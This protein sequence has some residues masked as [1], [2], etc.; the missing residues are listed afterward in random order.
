MFAFHKK[1]RKKGKNLIRIKSSG[2]LFDHFVLYVIQNYEKKRK[3]E[4]W[5]LCEV[6]C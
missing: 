6:Q 1:H 4:N 3:S 2:N 5:N